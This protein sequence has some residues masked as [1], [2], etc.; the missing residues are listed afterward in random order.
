MA[1]SITRKELNKMLV[2]CTNGVILCLTETF[3]SITMWWPWDQNEGH[4]SG[5][6]FGDM[7]KTYQ[8]YFQ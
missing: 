6:N 2:K 8:F 5:G 7:Y 3:Q 4:S 1:M